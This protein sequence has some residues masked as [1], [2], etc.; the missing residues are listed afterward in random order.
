MSNLAGEGI[1]WAPYVSQKAD[2]SPSRT[3][4]LN[5]VECALCSGPVFGSFRE[6]KPMLRSFV[7]CETD[8]GSWGSTLL[9]QK[10]NRKSRRA[11]PVG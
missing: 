9:A 4:T 10:P 6:H 3:R 11:M 2:R 8:G 7:Q 1:C 5:S